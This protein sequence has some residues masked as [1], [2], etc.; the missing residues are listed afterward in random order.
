MKQYSRVTYEE[1]C[2]I[3]AYLKIN[4]SIPNIAERLGRHKTTI[5][6]E[7]KRAWGYSANALIPN[8]SP[9]RGQILAKKQRKLQGRKKI[10]KGKV[11][12][13]VEQKLAEGWSPEQV[14]GR[15]RRESSE[16]LCHQTIY[17]F[18][19]EHPEYRQYLRFVGKTGIGRLRQRRN[20]R[21]LNSIH[22][23]P[24]SVETR[25]I[26]GHWER[27]GMYGANRKQ[28]LVCLERKSRLIRLGKMENTQAKE[29]NLLTEN[30][31]K[32]EKVLSI[33]NDN[34]TEFR[35]PET[36]KYMLYYCDPM[37]PNQRGSIENVIG[38]LRKYIKRSTNLD[39][40]SNDDLKKIEDHLNKTPRKIF[41]YRTPFEVYYKKKVALVV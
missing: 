24:K 23:R 30:L 9:R 20:R 36:S 18:I 32:N 5:Y 25:K 35:R 37:K 21:K 39:E 40:L 16:S 26:F 11:R 8:Y 12:E 28:L 15:L 7:V 33:T 4:L 3:F 29:V 17:R 34:G 2:Q 27:D 6:R 10:I 1:R 38:V 13:I 41:D 22:K 31:L 14:A 19:S